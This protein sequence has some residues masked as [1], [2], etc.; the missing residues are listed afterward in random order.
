VDRQEEHAQATRS[1]ACRRS[2]DDPRGAAYNTQ[3]AFEALVRWFF[4]E[5]VVV[6]TTTT[7]RGARWAEPDERYLTG[8]P[9][10]I[11]R[12]SAAGASQSPR[13]TMR[14][15]PCS[16]S[17]R[18][19]SSRSRLPLGGAGTSR[20]SCAVSG[21]HTHL[22]GRAAWSPRWALTFAARCVVSGAAVG[23]IGNASG[24][25]RP[26]NRTW[27]RSRLPRIGTPID[28]FG[29]DAL[30]SG[31]ALGN[32]GDVDVNGVPVSAIGLRHVRGDAGVTI[33]AG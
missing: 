17:R 32:V 33:V 1:A 13:W 21:T 6:A 27:S 10:R 25:A 9:E 11:A 22:A 19:R 28:Q 30:V 5:T 23:V 31:I 7:D 26:T 15:R 14:S 8:V 20:S 12:T 24:T 2:D 16:S 3:E 29:D 18:S 4:H